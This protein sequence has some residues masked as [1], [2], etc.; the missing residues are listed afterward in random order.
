MVYAA[1][2]LFVFYS[3]SDLG[4]FIESVDPVDK[5]LLVICLQ[6]ELPHPGIDDYMIIKEKKEKK[7]KLSD[8]KVC[9]FSSDLLDTT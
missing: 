5:I 1:V 7:Q 2:P 6:E 8:G 9:S 4:S 3:H